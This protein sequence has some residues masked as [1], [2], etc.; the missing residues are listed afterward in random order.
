[1]ANGNDTRPDQVF[2]DAIHGSMQFSPLCVKI[3]NTVQFQRLRN[4]KQLGLCYYVYPS[5]SHNR[6]EHCLGTCHLAGKMIRHLKQQDS[7]LEI[8]DRDILCVEIAG[9]CHDLGHA[10]FSHAFQEIINEYRKENGGKKWEHE[11]VSCEMLEH[12]FEMNQHFEGELKSG[13]IGF[14]KDLITG[15]PEKS[16]KK[17]FFY[18]IVNNADY[19]IDV[20]KWDYLARDSHFLGIGTSF[21][22]ERMMKMSKVIGG[23]ICYRDKTLKNFYDMFYSRYRLHNTAYQHKTVLLLNKLLGDVL[24]SAHKK[25][26]IFERVKKMEEFTYFT[27]SILEEILN[28]KGN[29]DLKDAL[30]DIIKRSF[31]YKGTVTDKIKGTFTGTVTGIFELGDTEGNILYPIEGTGDDVAV[32]KKMKVTINDKTLDTPE[33]K[34]QRDIT[35]EQ[36]AEINAKILYTSESEMQGNIQG[37]INGT[38]S[39]TPG[40]REKIEGKINVKIL[41]TS[42]SKMQSNIEGTIK[43][44]ILGTSESKMQ[45]NIEGTIKGTIQTIINSRDQG[46]DPDIVKTTDV[47]CTAHFDYGAKENNPLLKIPFYTRNERKYT[48]DN[49]EELENMLFLPEKFEMKTSHC[50][51]IT[52]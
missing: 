37:R 42:E 32:L 48:Y 11:D 30:K 43:G 7:G 10:P 26:K 25:L 8:S 28:S 24:K 12:L 46:S 41:S 51:E 50:F 2:Q 20:D 47:I 52:K 16:D 33:S 40:I 29:Q 9:L 49:H 19:N 31:K 35:E 22:H 18:Q 14:I 4:I 5:A 23:E 44:K 17:K 21:D 6:F 3:I 13:E 45:S 1:M 34:M 27:D 36:N 15:K 38:I 39:E